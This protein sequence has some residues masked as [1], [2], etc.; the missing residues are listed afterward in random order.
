MKKNNDSPVFQSPIEMHN[1]KEI[2]F[3]LKKYHDGLDYSLLDK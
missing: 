3:P 2:I 1:S